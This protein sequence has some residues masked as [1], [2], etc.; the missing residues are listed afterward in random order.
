MSSIGPSVLTKNLYLCDHAPFSH[1]QDGEVL[2]LLFLSEYDKQQGFICV[3]L[4]YLTLSS[5]VNGR[6]C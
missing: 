5:V 4:G 3:G 2:S 1:A 6:D